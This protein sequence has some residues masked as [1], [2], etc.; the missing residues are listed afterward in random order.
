MA[1]GCLLYVYNF[2]TYTANFRTLK[3]EGEL[4]GGEEAEREKTWRKCGEVRKGEK[5]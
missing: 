4:G 5:G 3:G 2:V 1:F